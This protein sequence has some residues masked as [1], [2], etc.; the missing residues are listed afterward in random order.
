VLLVHVQLFL[1]NDVKTNFKLGLH[2]C[3]P[4][5]ALCIYCCLVYLLVFPWLAFWTWNSFWDSRA[6]EIFISNTINISYLHL[7]IICCLVCLLVFL[8][9]SKLPNLIVELWFWKLWFQ[10]FEVLHGDD[11]KFVIFMSNLL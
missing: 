4:I 3:K 2:L 6:F 7:C 1:I 9:G 11:F 10:V 5:F 8:L